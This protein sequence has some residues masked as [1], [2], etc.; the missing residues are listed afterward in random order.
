MR[1]SW[2]IAEDIF[3]TELTRHHTQK[4]KG[5]HGRGK[6]LH[7]S[8]LDDRVDAFLAAFAS[9]GNSFR[10]ALLSFDLPNSQSPVSPA[11]KTP[12]EF[13]QQPACAARLHI[14]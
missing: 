9:D 5:I 12:T 2:V 13:I 3:A 14:A 11:A 1:A 6:K 7:Q 8:L 10:A 4:D